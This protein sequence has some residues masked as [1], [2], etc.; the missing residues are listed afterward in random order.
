MTSQDNLGWK[1][2]FE[3][4]WHKDFASIQQSYLR[5]MGHQ[6]TGRRWLISLIKKL[7]EVAW[8]LWED[9]NGIQAGL[10][11]QQLREEALQRITDAYARG[12]SGLHPASRKLF[13]SVSLEQRLSQRTQ[14]LLSWLL[15]IEKAQEQA[16]LH[17]SQITQDQV[18]RARKERSRAKKAA[19]AEQL[20]RQRTF[21]TEWRQAAANV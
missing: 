12:P 4:K 7:W 8:D 18:T 3:G 13:T 6:R 9:R 20:V 19:N 16:R 17:P 14:S 2:A 11:E 21:M 10:R 5:S 1:A 15:R